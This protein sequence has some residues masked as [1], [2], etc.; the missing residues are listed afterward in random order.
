MR[1]TREEIER[2][3]TPNG[4]FTR[5]TLAGWGVPWPPPKGWMARLIKGDDSL[6]DFTQTNAWRE[7][8]YFV[9]K[10]DGGKCVLCGRG[11]ADGVQLQPDHIKPASLFPELALD[12]D[13]LETLCRDCNVGKSNRDQTD[14]RAA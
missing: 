4:G 11:A 12:P 3:R 10:R 5:A 9:L 7:L 8:R 1:V 14:W 2:H 13:N 6:T